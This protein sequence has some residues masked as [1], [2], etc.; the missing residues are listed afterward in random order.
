MNNEQRTIEH[1]PRQYSHAQEL[2]NNLPYAAMIVLGTAVLFL[3]I[4]SA[5]SRWVAAVVYLI[6]G[7][8]GIF[9]II[10][11]LCPFCRYYGTRSCPCGYGQLA[12]RLRRKSEIEDLKSQTPA[13]C[14]DKKFK[15][16]IPVIVPLWFIPVLVGVITLIGAFS[17]SL[18]VLLIIFAVDAFVL[19]PL[20]STKH[21][22]KECPQR[23]TCP[24]MKGFQHVVSQ[25][26]GV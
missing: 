10:V 19:L 4:P 21:S 23:D 7:M 1:S 13:D 6:Y 8:T 22:C 11:F 2:I 16:H 5:L 15:R 14:F 9:W 12:A 20:L 24:W 25:R 18:L 26:T 17:I 3:S